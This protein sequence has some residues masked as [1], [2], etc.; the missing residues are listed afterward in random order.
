VLIDGGGAIVAAHEASV[1]ARLLRE[2]VALAGNARQRGG[3]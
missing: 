2:G 3:K 1:S